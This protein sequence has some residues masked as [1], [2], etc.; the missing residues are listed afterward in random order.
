MCEWR[1]RGTGGLWR[2]MLILV[3]V[4]LIGAR[5][6]AR[7]DAIPASIAYSSDGFVDPAGT[8][9][10][11]PVQFQGVTNGTLQGAGP[12]SLGKFVVTPPGG[13]D[14]VFNGKKFAVQ[15]TAPDYSWVDPGHRPPGSFPATVQHDAV[16]SV[17]G[18]LNGVVHADGQANLS[19]TVDNVML[20]GITAQTTDRTYVNSLPFP[21][22]D[23]RTQT[24]SL[25]TGP[26]G[27]TAGIV[28]QVVPEPASVLVYASMATALL[29]LGRRK[30]G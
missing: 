16:F 18:H 26:G 2:C 1:N 6:S 8:A 20:Q 5:S 14:V 21:L 4:L 25:S 12:I 17:F 15:F 24:L 30:K 9:G 28:V 3:G 13:G 11:S 27:G 22:S 7:G 23:V 19:A 10:R 29:V